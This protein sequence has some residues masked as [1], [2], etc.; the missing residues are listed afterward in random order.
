VG[1]FGGDDADVEREGGVNLVWHQVGKDLRR[2]GP[3]AA[4]W[5]AL[6]FA[7]A[8]VVRLAEIPVEVALGGDVRSWLMGLRMLDGCVTGAGIALAGLLT[9]QLVQEDGL[10]GTEAWWLT[11]PIGRGRLLTAKILGA[12]LMLVVAPLAVLLPVWIASGFSLG[13]IARAAAEFT[14]WQGVIL[15]VAGTLAAIT[16]DLGRF[17]FAVAGLGAVMAIVGLYRI[18]EWPSGGVSAGVR[19]T[20]LMLVW[21]VPVLVL[22]VV[23]MVQYFNRK[24]VLAWTLAGVGLGLMLTIRFAWPWDTLAFMPGLSGRWEM[25]AAATRPAVT[26]EKMVVPADRNVPPATFL[27][28]GA[29]GVATEFVTPWNGQGTLRWADGRQV[30]VSFETGGLWGGEAAK[31]LLGL[32]ANEG[33]VTWDAATGFREAAALTELGKEASISGTLRLARMRARVM[34]ELPWRVGASAASGSSSVRVVAINR[35]EGQLKQEVMIEE[36]DAWPGAASLGSTGAL[37]EFDPVRR[38]CF[39]LVNRA[40]GIFKT[41]H[42]VER[43]TLQRRSLLVGERMLEFEPP[44]EL[45]DG[46]RREISEWEREAVL[47]KVRFEVL[48]RW[49]TAFAT[50]RV[51]IVNEEKLP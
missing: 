50:D 24:T 12:T 45:V 19:E 23:A 46:K 49:Q 4:V 28:V 22:P 6:V 14:G 33:S 27:K 31:R 18:A 39:V 44:A 8:M 35:T 51:R 20:R 25:V 21:I 40:K 1:T 15:V 42:I 30:A 10:I 36:R 41:L 11:R 43:G 16:A 48:D 32:D 2:T 38:D 26:V 7:S 9:A 34:G 37:R 17:A 29:A 47:V 5:L 13:E 3:A